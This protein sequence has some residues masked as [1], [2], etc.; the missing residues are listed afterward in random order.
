MARPRIDY[1]KRKIA[2]SAVEFDSNRLVEIWKR[3]SISRLNP[4]ILDSRFKAVDLNTWK[5][6]LERSR[7]D[8]YRYTNNIKDC[9]NFAAAL[10]GTIPLEYGVNTVGFVIDYSG[11][12]AYNSLVYYESDREDL[13]IALVEPQNDQFVTT[14]DR[15]SRQ[16]AYKALNGM[17]IWG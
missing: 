6:I 9:D 13:R 17:I 4:I 14:D 8:K 10:F 16:E 2:R 5:L 12:H 1:V 7:I 3:S 15:L 11:Q